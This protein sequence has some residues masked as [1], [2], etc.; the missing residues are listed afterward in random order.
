M[1]A[2]I[3][4]H[5][6]PRERVDDVVAILGEAA[7]IYNQFGALGCRVYRSEDLSPKYGCNAITQGLD[8]RDGEV[9]LVELNVFES[10]E[11]HDGTMVRVDK[12][13]QVEALYQRLKSIIDVSR[14]VRGEFS[15]V[16]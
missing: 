13:S 3:Y 6:V 5:R 8:L 7:E 1:Y 12:D 10:K 4:I 14:T 2:S 16:M 15:V 11:H 9:M